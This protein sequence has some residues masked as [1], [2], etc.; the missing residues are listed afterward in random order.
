MRK[1]RHLLLWQMPMYPNAEF[2]KYVIAFFPFS[3]YNKSTENVAA[4]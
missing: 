3:A 4:Y 2:Q 1:K